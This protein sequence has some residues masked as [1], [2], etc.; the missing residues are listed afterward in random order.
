MDFQYSYL[1]WARDVDL[2]VE[3]LSNALFPPSFLRHADNVF[4]IN[5]YSQA[6]NNLNIQDI[7][8]KE[9]K[10]RIKCNF[11]STIEESIVE[12]IELTDCQNGDYPSW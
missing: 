12:E 2:D 3:W 8:F 1:V 4:L 5:L 10:E 7:I 6:K 11:I 9:W